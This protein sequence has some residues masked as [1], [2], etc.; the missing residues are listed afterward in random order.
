MSDDEQRELSAAVEGAVSLVRGAA[1]LDLATR[2]RIVTEHVM[3]FH[4][5][6]DGYTTPREAWVQCSCGATVW[7][8]QQYYAETTEKQEDAERMH[9]AM[10]LCVEALGGAA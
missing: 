6:G 1:D 3:T 7:G 10:M 4:D 9:L 8:W 5:G 2:T